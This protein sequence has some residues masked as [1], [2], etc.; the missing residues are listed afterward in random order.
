MRWR[1]DKRPDQCRMDQLQPGAAPEVV[2]AALA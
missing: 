2:A 1:P